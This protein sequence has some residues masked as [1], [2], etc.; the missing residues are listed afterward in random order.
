METFQKFFSLFSDEE[1]RILNTH[2]L[3]LS[4]GVE[5]G[6][7][8]NVLRFSCHASDDSFCREVFNS[9]I[10]KVDSLT[11]DGFKILC[12]LVPF[13][14]SVAEGDL[15]SDADSLLADMEKDGTV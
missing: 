11:H 14:V 12:S 1:K 15:L 10:S 3:D 9:L 5:K 6:H 8:L 13:S 7:F 2:A 4:G